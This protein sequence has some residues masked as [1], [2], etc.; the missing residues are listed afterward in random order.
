M[1]F[2]LFP[3][4]SGVWKR[5]RVENDNTGRAKIVRTIFVRPASCLIVE[6]LEQL[7]IDRAAGAR[8][9]VAEYG[10]RLFQMAVRLCGSPVDAEDYALRTLERAVLKI[11]TFRASSSFYHWLYSI[12]V[13]LIRSDVRRKGANALDFVDEVPETV[14]PRPDPSDAFAIQ[15]EA[16]AVRASLDSL[17]PALREVVV[18][19]YWEDLT[20]PEIAQILVIP[21]GTVK[22]RLFQAKKIIRANILRTIGCQPASS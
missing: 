9:L 7:K 5:L 8:R 21:E 6:L 3:P 19:R 2:G 4:G 18:F 13:N 20:V 10:A 14:D 15:E 11:D 22:S 16:A 17:P 12:L 1:V